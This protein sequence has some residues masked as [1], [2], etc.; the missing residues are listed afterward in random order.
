[1]ARFPSEKNK[2]NQKTT[3]KTKQRGTKTKKEA[4]LIGVPATQE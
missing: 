1:M 4:N 2:N 3:P